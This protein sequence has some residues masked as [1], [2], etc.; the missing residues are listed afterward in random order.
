M[1]EYRDSQFQLYV[2]TPRVKTLL[3]GVKTG[4]WRFWF[5]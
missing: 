5:P 2:V 4:R 3:L 1:A